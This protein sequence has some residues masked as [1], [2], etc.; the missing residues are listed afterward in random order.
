M[1]RSLRSQLAIATALLSCSGALLAAPTISKVSGNAAKD[2]EITISGSGF[3]TKAT[4]APRVWDMVDNQKSYLDAVSSSLTSLVGKAVPVGSS[5]VYRINSYNDPNSVVFSSQNLRHPF[6][7]LNYRTTNYTGYLQW[8]NAMGGEAPPS[9]QTDLYV[10][11]WIRPDSNLEVS[12]HSSKFIRIWDDAG[13]SGTR[14]S[15]TQMHLTAV[16]SR[17][18]DGT[19][20]SGW[21]GQAG[22]WNRLEMYVSS[23]SNVI[24]AWT[25]GKL[26]HNVTNFQKDSAYSNRGL[27]VARVGWDP[28]GN[29]PPKVNSNFGSIYIDTTQAR[30]EVCNQASWSQ[31]SKREVQPTT[32]WS[33]S[34]ITFKLMPGQLDLS[35][36]LYVYVVDG[37]GAVN[38]TG[39]PLGGGQSVPAAP[40][41]LSVN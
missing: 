24:K 5:Y 35:K 9:S 22:Q 41:L 15:W 39:I 1:P 3:G 25:N 12:D 21:S 31:C 17:G 13:G 28:G 16:N 7:K 8:P 11:F 20:W 38:S 4:A 34:S 33:S 14:I 32:S 30:V 10:S 29:S 37:S 26:I 18:Y 36:P 19:S 6:E 40:R 2:A 27:N 23:S